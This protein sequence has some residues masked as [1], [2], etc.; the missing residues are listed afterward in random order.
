MPIYDTLGAENIP[1]VLNHTNMATL[2]CSRPSLDVLLKC[3][4]LG[5]LKNIVSFDPVEE[6]ILAKYKQ[7]GITIYL[8]SELLTKYS[9]SDIKPEIKIYKP[10]DVVAFCYTSGTTGPPKGAMLSQKNF[11]AF[12]A[13]LKNSPDLQLNQHDTHLSYLP[14]AHI[15]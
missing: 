10:D 5:A 8:Y 7:K 11:A 1:F 3:D 12:A 9:K 2:F 4:N 15:L 6:D 14:L 13:V